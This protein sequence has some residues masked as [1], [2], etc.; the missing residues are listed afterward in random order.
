MIY[1]DL[2][3]YFLFAVL[4]YLFLVFSPNVCAC[5][6]TLFPNM[7]I[8]IRFEICEFRTWAGQCN[9][10]KDI[11]TYVGPSVER[12]S[13]L[14]TRSSKPGLNPDLRSRMRKIPARIRYRYGRNKT[15][16]N[17]T[18]KKCRAFS[19][20]AD[21]ISSLDQSIN[22]TWVTDDSIIHFYDTHILYYKAV[23]NFR[24]N[25]SRSKCAAL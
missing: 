19:R 25:F 21:C 16:H 1:V 10:I 7:T 9:R 15:W 23:R 11:R 17:R 12:T 5:G 18:I 4:Q 2:C 13:Y 14:W 8:I 22:A 6:P 3:A 20:F 24:K